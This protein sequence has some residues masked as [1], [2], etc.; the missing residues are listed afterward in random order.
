MRE[1]KRLREAGLAH[2]K[3]Y[4]FHSTG[5]FKFLPFP[6]GVH[7]RPFAVRLNRSGSALSLPFTSPLN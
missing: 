5:F 7:S 6:I 3:R 1:S 2:T 4:A